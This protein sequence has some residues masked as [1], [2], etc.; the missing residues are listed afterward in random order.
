L[1]N[2]PPN[3]RPARPDFFRDLRTADD[4]GGVA[5]EQAH[6]TAEANICRLVHRRQAASFRGSGDGGNY[7]QSLD[8]GRESSVVGKSNPGKMKSSNG[9]P[10][11]ERP[12]TND[13]VFMPA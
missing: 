6:D 13:R 9:V 4:N 8:A 2:E 7:K 3:F 5:H 12:A 1:L 11:R 10:T